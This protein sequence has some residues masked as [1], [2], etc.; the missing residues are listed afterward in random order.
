MLVGKLSFS[1]DIPGMKCVLGYNKY[2]LASQAKVEPFKALNF[3]RSCQHF[4]VLESEP[5]HQGE[6]CWE[7]QWL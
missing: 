1:G 2:F 3:E 6:A 7:E 5:G 4:C